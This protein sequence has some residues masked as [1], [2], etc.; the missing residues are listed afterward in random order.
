MPWKSKIFDL[1]NERVTYLKTT[2]VIQQTKPVLKDEDVKKYL[3]DLHDKFVIVPIDKAANNVAIICKNFYITRL[4]GEVDLTGNESETYKISN[5]ERLDI[6]E[7]NLLLCE[8]YS[9]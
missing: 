3:S 4:L 2:K 1:V 7:S 8:T 9:S 6:I 5:K